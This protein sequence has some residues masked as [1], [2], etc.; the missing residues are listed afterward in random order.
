M[1]GRLYTDD[2]DFGIKD[3]GIELVR[4]GLAFRQLNYRGYMYG[5]MS[6]AEAEARQAQRGFWT[7]APK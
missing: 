5:E 3:I 7:I 2:P 4:S 6:A 1:V